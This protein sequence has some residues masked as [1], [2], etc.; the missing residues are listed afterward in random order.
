ML[1]MSLCWTLRPVSD[2]SSDR[3]LEL[4]LT[5]KV[6][7]FFFFFLTWR[8]GRSLISIA[9]ARCYSHINSILIISILISKFGFI[10]NNTRI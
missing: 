2:V 6:C 3:F 4:V 5:S 8:S 9:G 10:I 7:D 1:M